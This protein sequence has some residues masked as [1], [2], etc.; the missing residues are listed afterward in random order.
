M[1]PHESTGFICLKFEQLSYG[2]FMK[3]IKV[4]EKNRG[5]INAALYEIEGKGT[6]NLLSFQT[7]EELTQFAERRLEKL[8]IPIKDRLGAEFYYQPAGPAAKAYKF[9]QG[10]TSA[11]IVRKSN[12]WTLVSVS[13]IKVYPRQ[14]EHRCLWLTVKQKVIAV[15]KFCQSFQT[16]AEVSNSIGAFQ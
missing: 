9:G 14:G 2:V 11:K 6:V 13:R 1:I 16:Q 4:V 7:I 15:S 8:S 3:E 5:I 10:A 12:G